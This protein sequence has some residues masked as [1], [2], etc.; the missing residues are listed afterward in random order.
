MPGAV[1]QRVHGLARIRI[2]LG[3]SGYGVTAAAPHHSQG[4]A[5]GTARTAAQDAC[6]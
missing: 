3:A 6:R 1:L 4:T 5:A 2:L